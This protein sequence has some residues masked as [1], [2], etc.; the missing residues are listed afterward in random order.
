MS[1]QEAPLS[2]RGVSERVRRTG[3]GILA[4]SVAGLIAGTGARLV[5]RAM[6][7]LTHQV[8]ALSAASIFVLTTGIVLGIAGGILYVPVRRYLPGSRLWK[9]GLFGVLLFLLFGLPAFVLPVPQLG[10]QGLLDPQLVGKSLFVVVF[11]VYG[12]TLAG[13]EERFNRSLPAPRWERAEGVNRSL[14]GYTFLGLLGLFGLLSFLAFLLLAWFQFHL[15][16]F[17]LV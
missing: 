6:V 2:L 15:F 14:V 16:P 10:A 1:Q 17:P 12:V 13:V 9:G 8:P 7:L 4:G 5:M 11:L 3:V